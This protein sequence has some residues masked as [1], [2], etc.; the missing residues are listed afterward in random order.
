[1]SDR[2]QD[3]SRTHIQSVV[4]D[5]LLPIQTRLSALEEEVFG[6]NPPGGPP[7]G[8]GAK[9]ED[10]AKRLEEL[11]ARGRSQEN[12]IQSLDSKITETIRIVAELREV[13]AR[14]RQGRHEGHGR[15]GYA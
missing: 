2:Q 3:R 10:L 6:K 14:M 5:L 1:M 12:R 11:Q 7:G 15:A 9:L 8:V 4:E 13:V